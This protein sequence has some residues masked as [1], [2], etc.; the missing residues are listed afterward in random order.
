[1]KLIKKPFAWGCM[2]TSFA[3]ALGVTVEHMTQL[4]GH[5]GSAEAFPELREPQC[6]R[7]FHV[8]ECILA[9][10]D[11]GFSCTPIELFPVLS[12]KSGLTKPVIYGTE[13][14]NWKQ[15][16]HLINTTRGVLEGEGRLCGHAVAYDMGRIFDPD[17]REYDYSREDC[18]ARGFITRRLWRVD[19]MGVSV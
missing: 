8:Q 13:L 5:D 16:R 11:L 4:I 18:E 9:A 6:R 15:F 10:L 12:T 3:M 17:G 7:A 19:Y 14:Q 2:V 1:M